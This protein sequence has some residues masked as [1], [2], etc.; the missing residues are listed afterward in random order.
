MLKRR[1]P[2]RRYVKRRPYARR[3]A[4]RRRPATVYSKRVSTYV[5]RSRPTMRKRR[6]TKYTYRRKAM[7]KTR[8]RIKYVH[9]PVP[10]EQAAGGEPRRKMTT[11]DKQHSMGAQNTVTHSGHGV[12]VAAVS[13]DLANEHTNVRTN[14]SGHMVLE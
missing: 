2:K 6:K 1:A 3:M 10:V 7:K 12:P 11:V 14:L 4:Y 9:V 13:P 5:R 8:T